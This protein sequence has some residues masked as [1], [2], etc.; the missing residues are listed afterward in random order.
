[1]KPVLPN[2]G[3]STTTATIAQARPKTMMSI[4][5]R[6]LPRMK[7]S[8]PMP[9]ITSPSSALQINVARLHRK[10]YPHCL[11]SAVYV[12]ASTGATATADGWN[13]ARL[14][15]LIVGDTP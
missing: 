7:T 4:P 15:L 3:S 1:M 8:R 6:R 13:S 12:A 9:A 11:R 5:G 10:K 14:R 2:R